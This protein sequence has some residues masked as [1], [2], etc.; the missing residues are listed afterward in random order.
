MALANTV[1]NPLHIIIS[2]RFF[3]WYQSDLVARS[4]PSA[5]AVSYADDQ[6][7]VIAIVASLHSSHSKREEEEEENFNTTMNTQMGSTLPSEKLDRNNFAS[8]EYKMHQYLV[9]QGA[10]ENQPVETSPQYTTWVQAASH[11]MYC[12]ATC[13]HDHMLG[14]ICEGKMPKEA[15]ENLHKIFAQIQLQEGFNYAKS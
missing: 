13:V 2:T 12:L 11:V 5:C 15:W 14:Y 4:S 7:P 6:E 9:G 1:S 10:H 8:W 3:T